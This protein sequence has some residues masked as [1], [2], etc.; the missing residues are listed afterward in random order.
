MIEAVK[1]P[2]RV[3]PRRIQGICSSREC[4]Y[5]HR[6]I[7]GHLKELGQVEPYDP[8]GRAVEDCAL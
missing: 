3:G 1:S 8:A 6:P 7:Y 5:R 4:I 2:T